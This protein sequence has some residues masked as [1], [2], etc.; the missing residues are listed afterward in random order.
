MSVS[1][2]NNKDFLHVDEVNVKLASILLCVEI[3]SHISQT[4]NSNKVL[5]VDSEQSLTVENDAA[6]L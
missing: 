3:L 5:L 1:M 4:C 6:L 2:K